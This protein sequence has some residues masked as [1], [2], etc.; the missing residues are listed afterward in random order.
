MFTFI[1]NYTNNGNGVIEVFGQLVFSGLYVAGGDSGVVD[2]VSLTTAGYA[3]LRMVNFI[4]TT[5]PPIRA[6]ITVAGLYLAVIKPGIA[7]FDFKVLLYDTVAQREF[8]GSYANNLALIPFHTLGL[9]LKR[10]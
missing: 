7:A 3:S 9:L 2:W 1:P 8:A 4:N 5:K 6:D 10:L